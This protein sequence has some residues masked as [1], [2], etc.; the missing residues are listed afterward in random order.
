M[1]NIEK[2]EIT[3]IDT[4]GHEWDGI[5]ELNTPLP[6]W[7]LWTFY[8]CIVWAVGYMIAYPAIPL[9]NGATKGLLGWSSRNDV[10]VA[11][12][13]AR[14]AQSGMLGRIA[15]LSLEEINADEDLRTFAV[16]GGKSAFAVNC[17]QCHGSGAAGGPGFP[18][19][20]DDEWIWGGDLQSIATSITDGIR[21]EG[22]DDTRFSEMPAFGRDEILE[23][24]QIKDVAEYALSLSG[25]DNDADAA[26]RGAELYAENCAACHGDSGGGDREFGAPALNDAIW[27]YAQNKAD[28]V[29]QITAPKH[30]VMPAWTKKLDETTIKK[31]SVYVHALGGG[32]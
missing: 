8:A 9:V 7:W 27:L 20:N 4:T 16:A 2:D 18:N 12:A 6:R 29:A 25:L 5:K 3:G 17:S 15:S 24:D 32:E 28:I 23:R 10:A 26:A 14:Q 30:G 21:D 22:D 1:A 19:L 31:L 13:D 11:M